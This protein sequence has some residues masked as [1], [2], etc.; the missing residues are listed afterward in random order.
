MY[1]RYRHPYDCYDYDDCDYD[2]YYDHDHYL[3]ATEGPKPSPPPS[4][5]KPSQMIKNQLF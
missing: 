3:L 4:P 1:N 2:G 5:P